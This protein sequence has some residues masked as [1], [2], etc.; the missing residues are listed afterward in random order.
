MTGAIPCGGHPLAAYT[1]EQLRA[2]IA[3]QTR[4][5]DSVPRGMQSYFAADRILYHCERELFRRET[6]N[7]KPADDSAWLEV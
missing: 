6:E 3:D 7:P 5:R 4:V 2:L 1:D